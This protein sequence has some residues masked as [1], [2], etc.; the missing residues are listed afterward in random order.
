MGGLTNKQVKSKS[1]VAEKGEV[2]TAEREVNAML[3]LVRREANRIDSR[4]L[5]P[6]C[7]NGNFLIEILRR[8]LKSVRR[9]KGTQLEYERDCFLAI[10]NIYGIDIMPDN[11]EE[12]RERLF[13]LFDK[14]YTRL[15]GENCSDAFRESIKYILSKNIV[16]G[17]ALTM[18][19]VESGEPLVLSEWK[20][21]MGEFVKRNDY[22]F[23][24]LVEKGD[25]VAPI[26]EFQ[27]IN[28]YGVKNYEYFD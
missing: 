7:G 21:G 15:Y 16:C 10:S 18:K 14:Q 17:D 26:K 19:F 6:S 4:F 3:D 12:S 13:T 9:Y 24:D 22:L 28:L 2:F 20:V 27:T 11:I 1:R 25:D 5:E 8:K 23:S